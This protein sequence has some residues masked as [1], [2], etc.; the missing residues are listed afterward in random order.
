[1]III[2]IIMIIIMIIII[3]II[4][5]IIRVL[6]LF[7][8]FHHGYTTKITLG[9]NIHLNKSQERGTQQREAPN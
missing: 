9:Q 1:M 5:I 7:N 3:I 4:I 2:I 6:Y 8:R